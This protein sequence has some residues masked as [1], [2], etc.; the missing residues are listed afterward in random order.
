MLSSV[1]SNKDTDLYDIKSYSICVI[2]ILILIYKLPQFAIFSLE[3][4]IVTELIKSQSQHNVTV[5]WHKEL[6]EQGKIGLYDNKSDKLLA[7]HRNDI[8]RCLART[9]DPELYGKNL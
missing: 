3:V 7:K 8:A 2:C 5:I 1:A 9:L 6:E 4:I